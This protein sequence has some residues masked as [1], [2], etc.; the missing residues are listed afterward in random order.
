V[1]WLS[2]AP[3]RL[4]LRVEAPGPGIL[5]LRDTF[6]PGWTAT[7]DG[8]PAP[9]WRADALFRAVPV[10]AGSHVV[11]FRLQSRALERGLLL[12][13]VA[14]LA[15]TALALLPLGRRPWGPYASS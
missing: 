3:E 14:L 6:Y 13:A 4:V 8:V 2:E 12:S 1:E 9:L 5:V 10:P 15:T 11:E 7:V